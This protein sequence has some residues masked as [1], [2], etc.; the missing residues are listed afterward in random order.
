MCSE[1]SIQQT[2]SILHC[3][4]KIVDLNVHCWSFQ[5]IC[6]SNVT[7]SKCCTAIGGLPWFI[8]LILSEYPTNSSHHYRANSSI[9]Q[10]PDQLAPI[11][12]LLSVIR[13]VCWGAHER[14]TASF[15][16]RVTTQRPAVSR[17][18]IDP[19]DPS[20]CGG[21]GRTSVSR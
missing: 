10:S 19:P 1:L 12:S 2:L 3:D 21:G 9:C 11:H 4:H 5:L 14:H 8:P 7:K 6:I 16:R 13:P 17:D 20:P 15:R 18:R